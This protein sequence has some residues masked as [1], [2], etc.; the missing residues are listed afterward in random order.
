MT[1]PVGTWH[2]VANGYKALLNITSNGVGQLGGTIDFGFEKYALQG[3]W[4]EAAQEI[5]FD[6]ID[7][8]G[9]PAQNYT[10][11]LCSAKQPI[12]AG[13]GRPEPNPDIQL[14]TGSYVAIG[15][16]AIPGRARF[17]WVASQDF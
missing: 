7:N 11:Y 16:G 17:A 5:V 6:L 14:L 15:S 10:G 9:T 8:P 12:F 3:V 4:N 2:M 13:Q 1:D